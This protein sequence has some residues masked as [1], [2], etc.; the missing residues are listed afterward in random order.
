MDTNYTIFPDVKDTAPR[1]PVNIDL[2]RKQIVL[3]MKLCKEWNA[4]R[5][6]K[7]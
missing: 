7:A 5:N 4:E 3:L 6:A 1:P 2:M